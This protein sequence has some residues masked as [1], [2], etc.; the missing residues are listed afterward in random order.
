M[1][2]KALQQ[3]MQEFKEDLQKIDWKDDRRAGTKTD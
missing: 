2:A 3:I 1:A